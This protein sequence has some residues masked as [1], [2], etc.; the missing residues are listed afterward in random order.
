MTTPNASTSRDSIRPRRPALALGAAA[1]LAAATLFPAAVAAGPREEISRKFEKTLTLEAGRRLTVEHSHGDVE[2]T[3]HPE[4][5]VAIEATIR[6]SSSDR[7]GARKFSDEIRIEAEP[8]ADGVSVRTIY[9]QREWHLFGGN[10]SFSVDYRIVMPA[11]AGLSVRNRFGDVSVTGLKGTGDISNSNGKLTFKDGGG[12]QRLEN[13]FGAI[14]LSG[15]AGDATVVNANGAATATDVQGNLDLRNRFGRTAVVRVGKRCEIV[16]SNG[17]VLLDGASDAALTGSFGRVEARNVAGALSI[18]NSNGAVVATTVGG[19]AEL[20]TSFGALNFSDVK[21]AVQATGTNSAVTGRK[22]GQGATVRTSFGAVELA[23][24]GGPVDVE[25]SNGR[26]LLRDARGAARLATRFGGVDAAGIAGDATVSDA[27]GTVTL[28]N[29]DGAAD[30]R[31]AFG[32]TSVSHVKKGVKIVS[33]NGRVAI[34]DV[35]GGAYVKTSFG[36][37]EAIRVGGELTVESSNGGVRAAGVKGGAVV[38]T[39]FAPVTLDDVAG[40]VEVDNQNGAVDVRGPAPRGQT[41][42]KI[43]LKSSFAPI[44]VA[45][46]PAGGYTVAARTSFGRVSTELPLTTSGTLGEGSLSGKIGDGRCDVSLVNSNGNIEI[47]KAPAK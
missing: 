33:G 13:S 19:R 34:A 27:N 47:V 46:D 6:V 30:V 31:N 28:A 9:P 24:I 29:V 12:R 40:A 23:D 25:N 35:G 5:S 37:V 20:A 44:R 16:S 18:S 8:S 22:V 39:S 36:A 45:L 10:I 41:C 43:S 7:E 21:G 1:A 17:D 11:A 26:I 42:P 2:I 14:E 4:S 38:R 15:L 32:E 3:T